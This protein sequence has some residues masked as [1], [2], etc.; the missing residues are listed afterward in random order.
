MFNAK[1][2]FTL[3]R[4]YS[5]IAASVS[6]AW[7]EGTGLD[8]ENYSDA[9]VSNWIEASSASSGVTNWSTAGGDYHAEPRFTASFANGTARNLQGQEVQLAAIKDD[10]LAEEHEALEKA[11]KEA[12]MFTEQIKALNSEKSNLQK[13]I[14]HLKGRLEEINLSNARLLY[15]NRVLNST[16][17]NERQKTRIVESISNADSVE[18][19]KVIYETLQNAVGESRNSKAPQSLREAVERP[20]PTLP[21]KRGAKAQSP[22]FDRMR[23]LAGINIKGD[24]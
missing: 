20:S 22:H 15:T 11:R 19:A 14:L 18:E 10:E 4:G 5:M 13:T 7:N 6:R 3:P 24:N 12:D 1:H 9:G 21:R 17:L 23:A 8:M 16:S 2:P